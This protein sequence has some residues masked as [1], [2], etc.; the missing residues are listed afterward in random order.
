MALIDETYFVGE[1]NIIDTSNQSVAERLTLFI[2]KYEEELL[3]ALLGDTLYDEYITGTSAPFTEET[4]E[5]KW[6][7]LRDGKTFTDQA[8]ND[9]RWM[10]FRKAS[11]KQSIIANYVYYWFMRDKATLTTAVGEVEAKT[12]GSNK[13]SGNTKM[14]R[15]WNEMVEWNRI[16]IIFLDVN[17]ETYPSFK[18]YQVIN[19]R[20]NLLS[21]INT[22]NI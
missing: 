5:Q 15:A 8:G 16:L 13:A 7:D 22:F 6:K 21:K 14:V 3:R 19:N 17:N 20:F 12:D 9:Y 18:R 11:S 10:G 2:S 4:I 1:T